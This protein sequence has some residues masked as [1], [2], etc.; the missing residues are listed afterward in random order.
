MSTAS[1]DT[2]HQRMETAIARVYVNDVEVG[3]MPELQ[4]KAIV[5][6]V[7]ANR[8]LRVRELLDVVWQIVRGTVWA[9]VRVPGWLLFVVCVFLVALPPEQLASLIEHLRGADATQL[10]ADLRSALLALMAPGI[11]AAVTL[12]LVYG[13]A[14]NSE[15]QLR[16][17]DNRI[18]TIMEC[19]AEGRVRIH[20]QNG[21]TVH[22]E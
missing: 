22:V 14:A 13:P 17:I 11:V 5:A 2:E 21:N 19:P 3:S 16:E 10:A 12:R 9:I 8:W 20:I 7:C 6:E 18:R 4:Y 1:L 15:I